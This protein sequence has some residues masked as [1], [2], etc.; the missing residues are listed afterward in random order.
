MYIY[1]SYNAY[2][3]WSMMENVFLPMITIKKSLNTVGY[4]IKTAL[5]A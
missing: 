5:P 3:C 2:V 1:I 4:Q